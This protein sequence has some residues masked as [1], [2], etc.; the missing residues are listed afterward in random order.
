M[1]SNILYRFVPILVV[2]TLLAVPAGAASQSAF[3]KSQRFLGAHIG[4]S[5]VG[6]TAAYG[7]NGEMAYNEHIGIGAWA[8]TWSYGQSFGTVLGSYDWNVRYIALAGTGSYHFPV[9]TQPKLDPFLGAALG[10]YVVHT[11]VSGSGVAGSYGG[12]GSRVFLGGFGGARYFFK[13]NIAGVAR[14]GFGANY[15]TLGVDWKM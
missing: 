2:A 6:S 10:Y 1:R 12:S 5:G 11:S 9:K 8:D 3:G 14:A 7:V 15:L 13:P 4:M